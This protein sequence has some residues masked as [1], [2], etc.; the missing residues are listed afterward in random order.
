MSFP[1]HAQLSSYTSSLAGALTPRIK[2][3]YELPQDAHHADARTDSSI[4]KPIIFELSN[5]RPWVPLDMLLG[6]IEV[7]ERNMV[8]GSDRVFG[9]RVGPIK[10][11]V[12]VM[13]CLHLYTTLYFSCTNSHF[14]GQDTLGKR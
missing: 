6:S 3:Y 10:V 13:V 8:G 1:T 9:N 14:S 4:I 12:R 5:G 11:G 2:P 7:L